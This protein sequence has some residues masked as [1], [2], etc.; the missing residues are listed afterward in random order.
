M[1]AGCG[2]RDMASAWQL[3]ADAPVSLVLS[4]AGPVRTLTAR[5]RSG[6]KLNALLPPTLEYAD[7]SVVRLAEGA[8]T[9]DSAYF[10]ASA[11]SRLP[12]DR[13]VAAQLRLSWCTDT[14][15]LCRT[16]LFP[17]PRSGSS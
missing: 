2:P 3:Q 6:V 16:R 10:A 9:A 8:R 7:G 1:L 4:G 14:E 12:Q 15:A 17:L 5:P 13:G 11:S